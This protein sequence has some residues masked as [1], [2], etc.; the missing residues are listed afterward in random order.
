M[1]RTDRGGLASYN[2]YPCR[3]PRGDNPHPLPTGFQG[4]PTR[5]GSGQRGQEDG[6]SWYFLGVPVASNMVPGI[7]GA[8]RGPEQGRSTGNTRGFGDLV[9]A[10]QV[11]DRHAGHVP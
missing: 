10:D 1:F 4:I 7:S 6:P 9:T 3:E 8:G 2:P 5:P 11:D